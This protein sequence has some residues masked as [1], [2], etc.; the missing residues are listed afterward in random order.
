MTIY[1]FKVS[2]IISRAKKKQTA[3]STISKKFDSVENTQ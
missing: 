2:G 3:K 1:N